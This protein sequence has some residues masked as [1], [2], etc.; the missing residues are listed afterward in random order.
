MTLLL[1]S[2]SLPVGL[3]SM[4]TFLALAIAAALLIGI[5]KAGFGGG[6]AIL[7]FPLMFYA[8]GQKAELAIGIT[9]PSSAGADSLVVESF[10]GT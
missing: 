2:M 9:L 8:C 6:I 5:A 10:L 1:A 4:A 7:S 3:P